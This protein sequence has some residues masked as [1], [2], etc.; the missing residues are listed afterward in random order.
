MCVA[1]IFCHVS[2]DGVVNPGL[3]S[4]SSGRGVDMNRQ[5]AASFHRYF[6]SIKWVVTD[7]TAGCLARIMLLGGLGNN[8]R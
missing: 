4:A 1:G 6:W 7:K 5:L 2:K 8:H 3:A